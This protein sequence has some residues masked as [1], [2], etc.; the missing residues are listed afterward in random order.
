[1]VN[2]I[3]I[4]LILALAP[5]EGQTYNIPFANAALSSTYSSPSQYGAMKAIDGYLNTAAHSQCNG[6]GQGIWLKLW[7]SWPSLI[8][9]FIIYTSHRDETGAKPGYYRFQ[10]AKIY[11]QDTVSGEE[12]LCGTLTL[13][14]TAASHLTI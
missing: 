14:A 7:L 13:D 10:G 2:I 9:H 1:M 6:L 4:G 3:I 12:V 5:S 11:L 8:D